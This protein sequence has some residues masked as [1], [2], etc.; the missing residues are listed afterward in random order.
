MMPTVWHIAVNCDAGLALGREKARRSLSLS[1]GALHT[2]AAR[3][4]F[5]SNP[6]LRGT[7]PPDVRRVGRE[8]RR[9]ACSPARDTP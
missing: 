2:R 8:Y 4:A 7:W 1:S 3:A 9:G 5:Q 6:V